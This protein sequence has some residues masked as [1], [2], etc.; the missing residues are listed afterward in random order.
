MLLN[1]RIP[2]LLLQKNLNTSSVT[3]IGKYFPV[4]NLLER[5]KQKIQL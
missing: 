3:A 4:M 5:A 2:D 1:I